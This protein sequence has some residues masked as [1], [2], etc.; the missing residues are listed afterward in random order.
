MVQ[1]GRGVTSPKAYLSFP[2]AAPASA[3]ARKRARNGEPLRISALDWAYLTSRFLTGDS[4]L[5]CSFPPFP[6]LLITMAETR[7]QRAAK[8]VYTSPEQGMSHEA[9]YGIINNHQT[10]R[11]SVNGVTYLNHRKN[12]LSNKTI[13]S[14]LPKRTTPHLSPLSS[15]RADRNLLSTTDPAK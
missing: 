1:Q 13:E 3:R 9:P 5:N 14:D 7:S 6:N 10:K 15:E 8:R 4:H 2:T 11:A 12:A